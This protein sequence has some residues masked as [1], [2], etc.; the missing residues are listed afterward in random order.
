[1]NV[2]ELIILCWKLRKWIIGAG[3]AGGLLTFFV[4]SNYVTY[5][6][7]AYLLV[8]PL[9]EVSETN[10]GAPNVGLTYAPQIDKFQTHGRTYMK[11][12]K[13]R[14]V[15]EQVVERQDLQ[16]IYEG[17]NPFVEA[18]KQPLRYLYYGRLPANK[19]TPKEMAIEQTTRKTKV[20]MI[21]LSSILE[22]NFRDNNAERATRTVNEITKV[23]LD[24]SQERSASS[25]RQTRENLEAQ[26]ADIRKDLK[27]QREL[28]VAANEERGS[29]IYSDKELERE[30]QRLL[31]NMGLLQDRLDENR[32]NQSVNAS[33]ISKMDQQLADFPEQT[34]AISTVTSNPAIQKLKESLISAN[35]A[36]QQLLVDYKPES[37]QVKAAESQI[38][39]IKQSIDREAATILGQ[40]TV[41][42]DPVRQQLLQTYVTLKVDT[43]ALPIAEE[44]LAARIEAQSKTAAEFESAVTEIG[45]ITRTIGSLL[46]T[47]SRLISLGEVAKAVEAAALNEIEVI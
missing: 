16:K 43:E 1:M 7:T 2:N 47:E 23:F 46:A 38:E 41:Q 33:K 34:K 35:V 10:L 13:S 19:M 21:T 11:L 36:L 6:A 28:L 26:I 30:R 14:H 29:H 8:K 39:F 12:I 40:E 18:I 17:A 44:S 42:L 25:V 22:L 31:T 20:N 5:E 9:G 32:Y 3:A 15:M 24:Y 27:E 45:E 37:P 4:G